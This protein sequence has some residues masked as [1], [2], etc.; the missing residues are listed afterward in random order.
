LIKFRSGE[1]IIN[2]NF[3][4]WNKHLEGV[5]DLKNYFGKALVLLIAVGM[6]L[7]G[8][9][10]NQGTARPQ[11]ITETVK[12]Y[13]G[14]DGNEKIVAE[15]RSFSYQQWE[16]KYTVVLQELIKGPE[17]KQ[18]RANISPETRVYGT[19][20]QNGAL[21]VNF[22]KEFNRFAGSM[23]EVIGVGTVV[24]TLTQ[25]E[26]VKKVKILVEG[27]ELTGP[28]GMPRGF[29]ETFP[30]EVKPRE[31]EAEVVLY[32]SNHD[33]TALVGETRTITFPAETNR[34]E[35]IKLVL[36]ELIKGPHNKN[37]Q[38]TIPPEVKVLSV[39]IMGGTAHTDFSEEMH[40][41]HWGGAT[42]ESMTI[43]S[44]V[45]VLTEFSY[46]RRVQMT[47]DGE[48][49]SIEHAILNEPVERNEDMIQNR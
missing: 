35:M 40:T 14:N 22:S 18:Y 15:E 26:A 9:G 46:I 29:M 5:A 33:A 36:E 43:N 4:A 23:A 11:T 10:E 49:M 16:D 13:Y 32:F 34:Q 38:P 44:I 45:N 19:I 39:K 37:L 24:N 8:C 20:E 7:G 2:R 21:V 17:K 28:G 12:L 3:I 31:E 6:V 41:K 30:A 48:P 47:V 27:E 25:F 1:K 42:G